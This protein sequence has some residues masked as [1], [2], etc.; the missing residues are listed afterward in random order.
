MLVHQPPQIIPGEHDNT[1]QEGGIVRI[2]C[3]KKLGIPSPS[4]Y[5]M[6]NG[7]EVKNNSNVKVYGA[8]LNLIFVIIQ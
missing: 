6:I 3:G 1:V 8:F 2:S 5:W 4:L 7:I